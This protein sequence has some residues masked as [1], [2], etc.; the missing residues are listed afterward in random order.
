MAPSQFL[1][2]LTDIPDLPLM[3]V[4]DPVQANSLLNHSLGWFSPWLMSHSPKCKEEGLGTDFYC[5]ICVWLCSGIKTTSARLFPTDL[6]CVE[7]ENSLKTIKSGVL[8]LITNC[9]SVN[10][11]FIIRNLLSSHSADDSWFLHLRSEELVM[12]L[13]LILI[14]QQQYT[15]L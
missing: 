7:D 14:K 3:S 10:I 9:F 6:T 15:H 4:G 8:Q 5:L 12:S 1:L 13:D 2:C 11:S